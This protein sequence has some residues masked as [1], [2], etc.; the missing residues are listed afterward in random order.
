MILV[1][2][3]SIYK[4][5]QFLYK[6][7][8]WTRVQI[9]NYQNEKLRKLIQHAYKNVPFYYELFSDLKLKPEDIQ[10]KED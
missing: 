9:D 10:T 2:G 5:L 6:S 8:Y 1:T 4:D 3:Q 7:Q